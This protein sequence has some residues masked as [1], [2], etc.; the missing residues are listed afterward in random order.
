MK[1]ILHQSSAKAQSKHQ[2]LLFQLNFSY[3]FL[4]D[5]MF[6]TK[7]ILLR[8]LKYL[9]YNR[10]MSFNHTYNKLFSTPLSLCRF[11]IAIQI[12]LFLSY[13]HVIKKYKFCNIQEWNILLLKVCITLLELVVFSNLYK[14]NVFKCKLICWW[15]AASEV[16][17][18]KLI[19]N[20]LLKNNALKKRFSTR[21]EN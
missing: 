10:V 5:S 16:T 20:Q 17:R 8:S 3:S 9:F 12:L 19:C 4:S 1:S 21:R 6:V 2:M 15:K 14:N 18:V 13:R 7:L 11:K